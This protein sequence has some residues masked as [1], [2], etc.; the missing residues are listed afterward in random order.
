VT[1]V[2]CAYLVQ[3]VYLDDITVG[4]TLMGFIILS[5]SE[6]YTVH[7]GACILEQFVGSVEDDQRNL[8]VTQNTQFIGLLHQTKLTLRKRH[9]HAIQQFK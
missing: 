2:W 6:Q 4:S 1:G 9:L 8:A 3:P 5:V 7:V